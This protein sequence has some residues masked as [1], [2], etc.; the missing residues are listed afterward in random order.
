MYLF[1]NMVAYFF[2]FLDYLHWCLHI[3]PSLGA[4]ITSFL[5]R[6]NQAT[7]FLV[8]TLCGDP[9][10]WAM[11]SSSPS[12]HLFS[13]RLLHYGGPIWNSRLA[14]LRS[15]LWGHP[16][17]RWCTVCKLYCFFPWGKLRA[18]LFHLLALY[19]K[20]GRYGI[21]DHKL[22][23]PFCSRLLDWGGPIWAPRL[24]ELRSV[25]W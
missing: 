13:S 10:G 9:G 12:F 21:C 23:S 3:S 8:R 17:G 24:A 14:E 20:G 19:W 1:W 16:W 11:A 7:V 15:V 18:G 6:D 25:L 22:L 4:F 5:P 2:I